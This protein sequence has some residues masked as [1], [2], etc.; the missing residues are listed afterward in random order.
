MV[1]RLK[2]AVAHWS[3]LCSELAVLII[4]NLAQPRVEQL[5]RSRAAVPKRE[6]KKIEDWNA[7]VLLTVWTLRLNLDDLCG[8]RGSRR[9]LES[10]KWKSDRWPDA[11]K[12]DLCYRVDKWFPAFWLA[13]TLWL[14]LLGRFTLVFINVQ[15]RAQRPAYM[16]RGLRARSPL[17]YCRRPLLHLRRD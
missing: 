4:T 3:K 12:K 5:P 1:K 15:G 17:K 9:R 6:A 7:Y 13:W 10:E 8:F 16:L 11:M 2:L 14:F